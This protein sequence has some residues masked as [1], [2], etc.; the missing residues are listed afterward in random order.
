MTVKDNVL[1]GSIYQPYG[2]LS[3]PIPKCALKASTYVDSKFGLERPELVGTVA[4]PRVEVE[5]GVVVDLGEMTFRVRENINAPGFGIVEV[6]DLDGGYTVGM[7]QTLWSNEDPAVTRPEFPEGGLEYK[8][9]DPES[10]ELLDTYTFYDGGRVELAD[11]C[12][13]ETHWSY[14]WTAPMSIWSVNDRQYR[15]R[16]PT[17]TYSQG[18]G[19]IWWFG[20]WSNDFYMPMSGPVTAE[21]ITKW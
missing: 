18:G 13:D 5:E 2:S 12:E 10:G 4:I 1:S 8:H 9:K 15:I 14:N 19:W 7:W 6:D 17:I 20:N 21:D 16:V 11:K 3:I